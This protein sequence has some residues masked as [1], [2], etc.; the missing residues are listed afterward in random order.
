VASGTHPERPGENFTASSAKR[1]LADSHPAGPKPRSKPGSRSWSI[2]FPGRGWPREDETTARIEQLVVDANWGQS[3]QT[4]REFCRRHASSAIILPSHGRGIGPTARPVPD[5]KENP[6]ERIGPGWKIGTISG[7]RGLL[8]DANQWKSF[9]AAR[10]KTTVGDPGALTFYQGG[11]HMLLNHLTS[12]QPIVD[13]AGG[14]TVDEWKLRPGRGNHL[15]D[16]WV[17]ATVAASAAG[18]TVVGAEPSPGATA[19][20]GRDPE[21]GGAEK[22]DRGQAG[23]VVADSKYRIYAIF[24]TD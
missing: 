13:S 16:C 22:E 10:L 8:L 1:P 9:L 3:A 18:I 6:G 21:G 12:E 23:E 14:R 7:Q 20:A 11:H 2:G 5:R 4:V 24:L 17:M 19:K 15:F